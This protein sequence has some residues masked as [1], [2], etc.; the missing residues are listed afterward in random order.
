V[1]ALAIPL[2]E[3]LILLVGTGMAVLS[4]PQSG[5]LVNWLAKVAENIPIVGGVLNVD[6]IVKLDRWITNQ[7][8]KATATVTRAG[9]RW[10]G[11]LNHYQDVV[12]YWSLYWPVGLFHAVTHLVGQEIP[13]AI[14]ARTKP[15]SRRIDH[16]EAQAKATAGYAHSFPKKIHAVDRTKQVTQIERVA[17][18]H[19]R[20]WEWVHEHFKELKAVIAG[21]IAGAPPIRLPHAPA[22]PHPWRGIR[23]E[24]GKLW[25]F[26][27][28]VLG[29]TG[30]AAIVATAIGGVTPRCVKSGPLGKVA[31]RLCGLSARGLEDLLGLLADVFFITNI[32]E[33]IHLMEQGLGLISGPLQDFVAGA[34]KMFQDCGYTLPGT[35]DVPQL[36]TASATEVANSG[37]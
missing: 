32:C 34:D 16:A 5:G 27:N 6:Q 1:P 21:A 28:Y 17:M 25:K 33:A 15:L 8:G 7:I 37:V 22:I 18:P 29:A 3:L 10:F 30:A 14:N 36:Y 26:R 31:R 24:L 2:I 4:R 13:H 35:L 23:T 19:A 11:A 12:G 9:V 20:E